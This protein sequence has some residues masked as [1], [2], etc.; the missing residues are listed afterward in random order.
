MSRP[1][2]SNVGVNWWRNNFFV[3]GELYCGAPLWGGVIWGKC[4]L[5]LGGGVTPSFSSI[6]PSQGKYACS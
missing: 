2:A 6:Y 3:L 5:V 1:R 4:F